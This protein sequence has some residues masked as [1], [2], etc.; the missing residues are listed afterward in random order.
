[1]VDCSAPILF[2]H[3]GAVEQYMVAPSGQTV[4]ERIIRL[5]HWSTLDKRYCLAR[6]FWHCRVSV[7]EC[8]QHEVVSIKAV[9]PLSF[10]TLDL[11]LAQARLDRPNNVQRDLVLDSKDVIEWPR[12]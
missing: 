6:P 10:V 11:S 2:S 1:M 4:S 8:L 3:S 7:G 9:G 12:S 5:K